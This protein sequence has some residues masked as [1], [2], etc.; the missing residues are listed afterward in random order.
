MEL[1]MW[2]SVVVPQQV[3]T[4]RREH[5][6]ISGSGSSPRVVY[7]V[8]SVASCPA[9]GLEATVG[10]ESSQRFRSTTVLTTMTGDLFVPD[11]DTVEGFTASCS[12]EQMVT[13]VGHGFGTTQL[14]LPRLIVVVVK[15][16]RKN[17]VDGRRRITVSVCHCVGR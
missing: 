7:C 13:F 10:P 14:T 6:W 3:L 16:Q 15:W 8:S 11:G 5:L 9:A 12:S 2:W 4:P 17:H 1:P